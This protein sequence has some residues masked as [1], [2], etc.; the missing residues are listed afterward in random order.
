MTGGNWIKPSIK[1]PGALHSDLGVPQ[2]QKIP[3]K[4]IMKAE[5]ADNPTLAKRAREAETLIHLHKRHGH[6]V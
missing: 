6:G 2:G 3:M 5:H 4:K 1:H